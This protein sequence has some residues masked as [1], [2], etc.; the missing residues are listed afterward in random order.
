[1]SAAQPTE[2]QEAAITL[3]DAAPGLWEAACAKIDRDV[4]ELLIDDA[5]TD[6]NKHGSYA[7]RLAAKSAELS[8]NLA[9]S[10]ACSPHEQRRRRRDLVPCN[11]RSRRPR[12]PRWEAF[13][14]PAIDTYSRADALADGVL[15]DVSATAREAGIIYPVALTS[16][17]H[18]TCVALTDAARDA[19]C[20]E[21][22]ACGMC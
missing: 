22:G 14:G 6:G 8:L 4:A 21:E 3:D 19:G 18:E 7:S 2:G 13:Y 10:C 20:D 1:M 16:M 12:A 15:I 9:C 5:A 11:R 17:V